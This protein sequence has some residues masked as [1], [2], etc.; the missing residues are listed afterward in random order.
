M[1]NLKNV[2][3]NSFLHHIILFF[4]NIIFLEIW[5]IFLRIIFLLIILIDYNIHHIFILNLETTTYVLHMHTITK[6]LL[7]H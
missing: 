1:P 2:F 3:Q 7:L 5:I 6:T 4:E